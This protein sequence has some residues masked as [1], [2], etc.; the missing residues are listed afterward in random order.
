[1]LP[2]TVGVAG[3]VQ[4]L[5]VPGGGLGQP[6]GLTLQRGHQLGANATVRL[7]Q[8]SFEQA[9]NNAKA[10]CPVSKLFKGA[11]ISMDAQLES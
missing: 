11:E 4:A 2:Q 5:V 8:A 6:A 10:G 1:M 7:D 9:M 3:A